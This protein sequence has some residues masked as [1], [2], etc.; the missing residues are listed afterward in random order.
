[1]PEFTVKEG[2]LGNILFPS[3]DHFDFVAQDGGGFE[4]ENLHRLIHLI[5][6]ATDEFFL[7]GAKYFFIERE[8]GADGAIVIAF[9]LV[10]DVADF[11]AN[12]FRRDAVL[13]IVGELNLAAAIGLPDRALQGAG[14][15]IGIERDAPRDISDR[16]SRNRFLF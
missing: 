4:I 15:A 8:I 3:F 14:H 11:F 9:D 5:L 2:K 16:S 6:L 13:R 7:V 1:M 10:G 12:R